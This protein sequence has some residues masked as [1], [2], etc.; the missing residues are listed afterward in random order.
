MTRSRILKG[1]NANVF[2]AEYYG[3]DSGSYHGESF[4]NPGQHAYGTH[5]GQSFGE[6]FGDNM[7]GPNLAPYPNSSQTQT[8]GGTRRRRRR[9]RTKKRRTIRKV[10][11]MKGCGS[12]PKRR[13][14]RGRKVSRRKRSRSIKRR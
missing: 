10:T 5:V 1:G 2:P 4:S 3:V 14:R 13:G 8:G 6:S 9:Q 11:K 12:P 7:T